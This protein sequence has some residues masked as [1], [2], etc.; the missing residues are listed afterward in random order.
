MIPTCKLLH[1]GQPGEDVTRSVAVLPAILVSLAIPG[2]AGVRAMSDARSTVAPVTDRIVAASALLPVPPDVAFAYFTKNELL[3]NW[4]TAAADVE[5]REGGKYELFWEP[6]DRQNNS[7]IGCRVTAV[8]P[9][10]FI[11]FQWRSPRHFKEFANRS[12][13]LTHVVVLFAPEG[14]GTRVHL[15][16]SGWRS[17]AD[18]EEARRWQE[19]AWTGA[20]R[21]LEQI[22]GRQSIEEAIGAVRQAYMD[23][24]NR[25]DAA[26]VAALHTETSIQMPAGI[27]SVTGR[28]SIRE[29]MQA[30]LSAV[31]SGVQFAFESTDFRVAD[32]W[33]VERGITKASPPFPAGKYVMMYERESDGRWRIA[34]T[35]TNSDTLP[36]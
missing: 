35:I 3:E 6:A 7:T 5:A 31:P 1:P 16:H 10:Q 14:A 9:G 20:F 28:D 34:W 4:L 22:A 19:R 29:L 12:D 27:A 17:D 26:A 30:S 2:E 15:I 23:A 25:G 13:P 33:A 8:A 11:A 36:R 24:F 21:Q 18:W 32:G